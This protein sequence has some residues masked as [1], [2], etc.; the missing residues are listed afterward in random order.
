MPKL[1]HI[2]LAAEDPFAAACREVEM[3]RDNHFVLS[4]TLVED[5]SYFR[6]FRELITGMPYKDLAQEG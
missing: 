2:A 6:R 3:I 4:A 5:V 1:R